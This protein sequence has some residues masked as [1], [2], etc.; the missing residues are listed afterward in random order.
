MVA[1]AFDEAPLL[2][3]LMG[4][5]PKKL[6]TETSLT[7]DDDD[8]EDNLTIRQYYLHKNDKHYIDTQEG[9]SYN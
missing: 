1:S 5:E 8:D 6:S 9:N 3:R 4:L 7:F 2:L